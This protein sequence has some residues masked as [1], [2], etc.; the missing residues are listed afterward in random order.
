VSDTP[1]AD[2]AF[3]RPL[4]LG[5]AAENDQLFESLVVEF[6]RPWLLDGPGEHSYIDLYWQYMDE[7]IDDV[8]AEAW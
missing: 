7:V 5:P 8:L 6:L 3:V 1:E 4:F 2:L